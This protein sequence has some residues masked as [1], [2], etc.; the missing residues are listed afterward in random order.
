MNRREFTQEGLAVLGS[1]WL[2]AFPQPALPNIISIVA[3]DQAR[4]SI[5]AYGNRESRTPNID[6]LAREGTLFSNAFVSTPVCSPS[7]ASFLT[8][9]YGTQLGITDHINREDANA[10]LGLP[11]TA[12][13][14]P[15]L[16]KQIGY[17]TSLFGKWHL[18][19]KPQF[20]P[21][22]HGFDY[23]FG[24]LAGSFPPMNPVL[25]LD[26]KE[27]AFRGAGADIITDAALT[28]IS[29]NRDRPFAALVHFREPHQPYT[30]MP[31]VDTRLFTDLDPMIPNVKGLDVAQVK[32]WHREYYACVHAIDRN[33]GR[34]LERLVELDLAHR[35]IVLYTSDHGYNIGQHGIH[36]KGNGVW[37]AGE[38]FGET[39]P[40]MYDTSITVPLI[41]RWPGI[42]ER[43]RVIREMVS[44]VDMLA[45]VLG[46]IGR[47][48]PGEARHEGM[49]FSP[50]LRG[51]K[52]PWRDAIFG[53]YDLHHGAFARL[54]MVR[55]HDWK[56]VRNHSEPPMNELYALKNDPD[57]TLNVYAQPSMKGIRDQLERRLTEWQRSIDDPLLAGR[58]RG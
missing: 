41:I 49:D 36:M 19:T 14:W 9:K 53:Q 10:G 35:T 4:W 26:G 23:F 29:E 17:R 18:G 27:R 50:L 21:Q 13:T 8:G 55:T 42:I 24:S 48:V 57:E 39:R 44:N 30:P 3:D 22:K 43:G 56:L 2:G 5:G 34:L 51:R 28:F 45:S 16:L 40:N 11:A 58:R 54:R 15:G 31:E 32:Q 38:N 46:L 33:L 6:R 52:V 25:E 20:H 1:P 37:I 47:S 12:L 7:R